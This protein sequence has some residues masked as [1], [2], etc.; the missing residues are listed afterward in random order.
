MFGRDKLRASLGSD[1]KILASERG[2]ALG[3][4][5]K[6]QPVRQ[7]RRHVLGRMDRKIDSAGQQRVLDLLGEQAFA[8]GFGQ[9]PV[10]DAVARSADHRDL[11]RVLGPA[12]RQ[13]ERRAHHMGL[14]QRERAAARSDAQCH[15]GDIRL[16][17]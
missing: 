8:A 10:L 11:D 6:H 16:R 13:R 9:R 7:R 15:R 1:L 17:H 2:C 12:M 4:G 5:G 14:C 3:K